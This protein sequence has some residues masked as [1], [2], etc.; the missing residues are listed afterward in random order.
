M[1]FTEAH[2]AQANKPVSESDTEMSRALTGSRNSSTTC[3]ACSVG[4]LLGRIEAMRRN[5]D[6][7][8][9]F[10]PTLNHSTRRSAPG[11]SP[12]PK[13]RCAAWFWPP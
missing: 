2:I 12:P 4:H 8:R 9:G 10:E 3:C 6:A 11:C 13:A 1:E 7:A 5:W